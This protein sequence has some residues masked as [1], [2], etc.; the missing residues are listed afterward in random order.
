MLYLHNTKL[1]VGKQLI[2]RWTH[3]RDAFLKS[4]KKHNNKNGRKPRPYVYH[5]QM[6]F[7]MKVIDINSF[8]ETK[9]DIS[10]D[11]IDINNIEI[12]NDN[13][14][15][16]EILD[17]DSIECEPHDIEFTATNTEIKT[18]STKSTN[19]K[20]RKL[21]PLDRKKVKLTEHNMVSSDIV[22][23]QE[24]ES[25]PLQYMAS[26]NIV[27]QQEDESRYLHS[28]TS[29]NVVP[30]KEE[31]SR[32]LTFFKSILPSV[33]PFDDDETLELQSGVLHLIRQIKAKRRQLGSNREHV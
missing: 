16:C 8:N 23:Q 1:L 10:E 24:E 21:S 26:S 4:L 27:P 5:E 17:S 2:K 11:S 19:I 29:S 18:N 14:V 3:I 13:D 30:Q 32:H 33:I 28:M 25:D 6:S 15:K 31:E 20:K 22:S 12:L 7:L 9:T